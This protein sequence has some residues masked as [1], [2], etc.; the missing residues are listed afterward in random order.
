MILLVVMSALVSPQKEFR[1]RTSSSGSN[2]GN[3]GNPPLPLPTRPTPTL[4]EG[5]VRCFEGYLIDWE[6]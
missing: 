3:L 4:L 5:L 2:D 1:G 6:E